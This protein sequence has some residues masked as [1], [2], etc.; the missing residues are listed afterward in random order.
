[1]TEKD[2]AHFFT[3]VNRIVDSMPGSVNEK[4][5]EIVR[6]AKANEKDVMNFEEFSSWDFSLYFD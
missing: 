5:A 3:L 6:R 1:M 2:W 4:T